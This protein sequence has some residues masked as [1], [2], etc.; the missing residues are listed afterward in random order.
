MSFSELYDAEHMTQ[1]VL[2][3]ISNNMNKLCVILA[4][5]F[6]SIQAHSQQAYFVDGYHGGIY[7]HYPVEWKTQ[8]I[9]DQLTKN[10]D[11]RIG[12]EIE[13]ETW[14]TVLVRTPEAYHQFAKLAI[15]KQVEFTN[16]TYAQPY[17]YNISGESIIRQFQ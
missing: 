17:C 5:I 9:V 10:P 6:C 3:K 12:I 15:D 16:P 14:D 11:W 2:N 7:G 8:F 1:N 4:M 13:P